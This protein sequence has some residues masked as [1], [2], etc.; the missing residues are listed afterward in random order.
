MSIINLNQRGG[1][2]FTQNIMADDQDEYARRSELLDRA[3]MTWRTTMSAALRAARLRIS[4]EDIV[5]WIDPE[6]FTFHHGRSQFQVYN[7]AD[8]DTGAC[9]LFIGRFTSHDPATRRPEGLR[10]FEVPVLPGS[11]AVMYKFS[12]VAHL[13]TALTAHGVPEST[14]YVLK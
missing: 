7:N 6:S 13:M 11:S 1:L 9:T 14:H 2:D 3:E 10:R 12:D 4:D 8:R 5:A